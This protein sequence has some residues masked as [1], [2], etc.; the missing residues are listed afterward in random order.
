M[1][2]GTQ[3][4]R[5]T[6]DGLELLG[7][8]LYRGEDHRSDRL[9]VGSATGRMAINTDRSDVSPRKTCSFSTMACLLIVPPTRHDHVCYVCQRG[10]IVLVQ[11]G[12]SYLDD[13]SVWARG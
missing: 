5:R 7:L 6:E 11:G 9:A 4:R 13:P 3:V 1:N 2:P 12:R 8:V 10:L